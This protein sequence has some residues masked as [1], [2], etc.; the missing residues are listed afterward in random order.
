[1]R[2]LLI[3]ALLYVSMTAIASADRAF[4]VI[5]ANDNRIGAGTLDG[6][7][8]HV[9]LDAATGR[10][11]PDGR[12][13]SAVPIDAFAE[14]GKAPQI[15][16]PL[17]R[18]RT[19]TTIVARIRNSIP[20]TV[21]TIHGMVTR[22]TDA[23]RPV[24]IPFGAQKT[25]RFRTGV[26]G[27]Y[28]YWGAMKA[29]SVANRFGTD[30]QLN[31]AIVVDPRN[32]SRNDR[33]FVIGQWLNVFGKHGDPDFDY[34]LDVI[35]GRAWPHTERLSYAQHSTIHWR[36]INPTFGTHPLHL[37]GFYF[38]V[39]SRGD[40][41]ADNIYAAADR[42]LEVTELTEPGRTFTMTWRADRPGNWL[43][44][45]HFPYH[46]MHHQPVA[47]MLAGKPA[48][49]EDA[50]ENH[51][52][53]TAG[54]GGLILAVAVR[55]A[56]P[57]PPQAISIVQRVH[58]NVVRAAD[59]SPSA[60]SFR[61]VLGD[62]QPDAAAV[63]PPI[64]LTRGMPAAIDV[65]NRLD[66]PTAVHWHGIELAD[67]YYDGVANYSGYGSRLAPMIDPG[68]TFEAR[69]IAPRSGT[70]IY[71]THMDDVYQLRGGLAGPLIVLEPRTKFDPASDHV[72]TITTTHG[73]ADALFINVNGLR[74]PPAI[75]VQAGVPQRLRFINMTTFWTDAVVSL[76]QGSRTVR[77][78]P[79]QVD[80]AYLP[81]RRR[82]SE[83]AV[84]IVTIGQTRD[85]TFTPTRAGKLLLQFW[86]DPTVPNIVT[87]P[88]TV[89][90]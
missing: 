71:H 48:L 74:K 37:H 22:P 7:E 88:I 55:P 30:S 5:S 85:F 49:S 60:P 18:V 2:F 83:S 6:T 46:T 56:V 23:D 80:G 47:A 10:W 38:S 50:Y 33:I 21:L 3:A 26:P 73:L 78:Q 17:I 25:V 79:L 15:P 16:G 20:G 70:F 59:S 72:F 68:Q 43:F 61:Y 42:D 9:A 65:T 8:L 52:V 66:E 44:H 41:L 62:A 76:S 31:G 89:A 67:S 4:P 36:I 34:E 53:R 29:A 64:V 51:Y 84:D 14:A 87:I 39:D 28:Y 57:D 24:R 86:P 82:T 11:Y 75:T 12:A 90:E 54:M 58:L 63:G 45:C 35:N 27:T 77:W 40:G 81:L 13:G 19:G 69:V 1:M 32:G